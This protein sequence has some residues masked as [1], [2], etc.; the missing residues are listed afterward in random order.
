MIALCGGTLS[1]EPEVERLAAAEPVEERPEKRRLPRWR[2]LIAGIAALASLA[3]FVRIAYFTDMTALLQGGGV[4]S[5]GRDQLALY[6][7]L[8]GA[9]FVFAAAIGRRSKPQLPV[10]TP[11]GKRKLAKRTV[12]A[13]V[14]ILLLI[15]VTLYAGVHYLGN[16]KYYVTALLVMLE[17]MLPFFL[18]FEG[19]KPQARELTVVAV[20]C[21]MGVASR[22]AFFMLPQFKPVMAL[23]IL[24]GVAFGGE[25]GFLVGAVTMLLSTC[26]SLRGHGRPG[27]CLAWESPVFGRGTISKGLLRRSRGSLCVFG[28]LAVIIIYGGIMNATSLLMWSDTVS[29][30]LLLP[31][32]ISGFPMDCVHAAATVF[33][34][35]LAGEPM[36]EKL[37]R[38]QVKYGLVE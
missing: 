35:W 29:W 31:Y 18:I 28:A 27:R 21:A 38:I 19:R 30:E 22:A 17:C 37:E 36:L 5:Q 6:A 32:Y 3:L 34:L 25:T 7:G 20:L 16:R 23:T 24:A 9:L 8:I 12:A 1:P 14:M 15:P 4:T 26:F 2:R 33:F 11:K 10:R 13:A